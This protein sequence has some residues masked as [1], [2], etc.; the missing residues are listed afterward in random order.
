[1]W[2]DKQALKEI[3]ERKERRTQRS[4]IEATVIRRGFAE[5]KAGAYNQ[6]KNNK[7][8]KLTLMKNTG[9]S[10]PVHDCCDHLAGSTVNAHVPQIPNRASARNPPRHWTS[11]T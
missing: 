9:T 5:R 1:M 4:Y 8:I 6:V 10:G 11:T 7:P 3:K 2:H